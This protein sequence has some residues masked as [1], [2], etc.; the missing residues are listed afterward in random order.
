MLNLHTMER[1]ELL[2]LYKKKDSDW[3][4]RAKIMEELLER[5]DPEAVSLWRKE[6]D[7]KVRFA[8]AMALSQ[9]CPKDVLGRIIEKEVPIIKEL[10]A[11]KAVE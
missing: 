8:T 4:V 9:K 6:G 7:W 1:T 11:D 10:L 3:N 5:D 2:A